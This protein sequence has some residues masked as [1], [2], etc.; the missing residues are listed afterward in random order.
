MN[1]LL[2]SSLQYDSIVDGEGIRTVIWT[3][4]CP[5]NCRGCHNPQTHDFNKGQLVNID[6]IKKELSK[7]KNQDGITL[8][9]GE[10]FCQPEACLEIAIYAKKLDL[11]VWCYTGYTFEQLL[12]MALVDNKY[13]KLLEKIDVLIDGK[14]IIEQ[15]TFSL[16][17]RGSKNQ[18]IID[19][20]KSLKN[21][22]VYLI[23]KYDYTTNNIKGHYQEQGIF[24]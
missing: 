14:F 1:I 3:Q 22:E 19:V 2:S 16:K 7:S 17:F 18:R 20:Q 21:N 9:G 23:E 5:H 24:V 13:I 12:E 4:G 8:S 11:N 6:K 15:K 10:P